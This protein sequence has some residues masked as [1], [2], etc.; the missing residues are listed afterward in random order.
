LPGS[1]GGSFRCWMR[2]SAASDAGCAHPGLLP[3]A[4]ARRGRQ[5]RA[6]WGGREEGQ[7]LAG[8][9]AG[10]R[11]GAGVVGDAAS[12]GSVSAAS[13]QRGEAR[14]AGV[15]ARLRG[16][17]RGDDG[18][19]GVP[20]VGLRLRLGADRIALRD[21]DGPPE[22]RGHAVGHGQR[23]VGHG[24]GQPVPQRPVGLVLGIAAAGQPRPPGFGLAH[25]GS[26]GR[27]VP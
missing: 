12:A 24:L 22:G 15:A 27:V 19:P 21:A 25:A 9:H 20:G 23:G 26:A 2:T 1:T 14:R 10:V 7:G 6:V 13:P 8:G 5:P 17:A 3:P 4:G 16:Q 18:L 11:L